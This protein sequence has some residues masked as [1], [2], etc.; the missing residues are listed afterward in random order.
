MSS[1][2]EIKAVWL[3]LDEESNAL[4]YLEK[5][6]TYLHQTNTGSIAWK[7][8][9]LALHGALYGFAIVASKG[10]DP[11]SVTERIGNGKY[12]RLVSFDKA[13]EMCQD[14]DWMGTMVEGHALVLSE[15]QR[16]SVRLLKKTLRNSFEHFIPRG[17]IVEIHGLPQMTLDIIDII[18]FLALETHRYQN[19]STAQ[20]TKIAA[21]LSESQNYIHT[22]DLFREVQR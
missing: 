15:S 21:L 11:A 12:E 16:H 9:I 6:H 4:D 8:V 19:F 13:L 14:A 17:W 2:E 3:K 10:S 7:W 18:Q 5:A 1:S 20:R 22:L